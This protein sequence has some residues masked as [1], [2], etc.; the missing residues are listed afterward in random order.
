MANQ[1]VRI[2]RPE[3]KHY[4]E[5]N[6]YDGVPV[7][8]KIEEVDKAKSISE[9]SQQELYRLLERLRTEREAEDVI[10]SL[11]RN[12]G[13]RDTFE[14]PFKIDTTTPVDQ[15]YHHGIQG[16]KWG[17]RRFQNSDGSRTAAGKKRD[18]DR[19]Y[20]K[21]EDHVKS[22]EQKQKS[23]DGLSNE[24]LRKLNERLQ[25]EATYKNLTAEKIQKS[26]SFVQKAIKDAAGSAL[27]E[28]SKGIFLGG[29]KLLVKEISPS[30]AEVA[31]K[32]KDKK[33]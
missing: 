28:F 16:M 24:E 8:P 32:V 23:P 19:E 14:K 18:A 7:A 26:E 1:I 31:F 10:K 30:F 27:T 11:R 21:S 25:L 15:L 3:L 12:S 17:V 6:S 5:Y 33:D 29:A 20:P 4:N 22:R 9:L 13:E 2:Q